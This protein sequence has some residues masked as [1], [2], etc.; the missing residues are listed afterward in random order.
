MF[1]NVFYSRSVREES[2]DMPSEKQSQT[3]HIDPYICTKA[4][5]H[6]LFTIQLLALTIRP[7]LHFIS[8]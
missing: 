3:L 5:F 1:R 8:L 7:L 4:H 2:T 6:Q